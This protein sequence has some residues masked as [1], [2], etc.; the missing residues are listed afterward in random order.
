[1]TISIPQNR[2][3]L[4]GEPAAHDDDVFELTPGGEPLAIPERLVV[5][6]VWGRL[7]TRGIEVGESLA[8]GSVIGV[9][10]EAG[11]DHPLICHSAAVFVAWLALDN[12]RVPPGR[13]LARLLPVDESAHGGH[14]PFKEVSLE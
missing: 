12:E 11:Q 14:L 9:I 8:A 6:P 5:A 13:A 7:R 2:H 1:M 3:G 4:L 10:S